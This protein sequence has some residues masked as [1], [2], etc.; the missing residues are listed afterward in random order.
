MNPQTPID[1]VPNETLATFGWNLREQQDAHRKQVDVIEQQLGAVREE[2]ARR[3]QAAKAKAQQEQDAKESEHDALVEKL[4]AKLAERGS[5]VPPPN[6]QP[7]ES[8]E[9]TKEI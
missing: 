5:K 6:G 8:A 2:F 4:A 7:A 9:E 1:Q 3:N